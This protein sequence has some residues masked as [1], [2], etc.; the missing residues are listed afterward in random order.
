MSTS[1]SRFSLYQELIDQALLHQPEVRSPISLFEP[2]QYTI[3]L[4]GK[5]IRPMLTMI[6]AGL[7]GGDP[8]QA[9][10]AAVCVEMTHT[11]TLIHDDIMDAADSRRGKPTVFKKW[12]TSKAILAGDSLFVLAMT[13]INKYSN[14]LS[15]YELSD[16]Y[17]VYFNGVQEVCEGQ[18][19]DLE[20][21]EKGVTGSEDYMKMIDGK[22][23]ALLRTALKMGGITAH[24]T[25][26]Q[27]HH[28]SEIGTSLGLAFQIQ[29]DLL[30]VS[31]DFEKLGKTI[32]GDVL[33]GKMTFLMT[34]LL[35]KLSSDKN[36][37]SHY[38]VIQILEKENRNIDDVS[39]ML[40][41]FTTHKILEETQAKIDELYAY[42]ESQLQYFDDTE[43]KEDL[44]DLIR[45]LKHRD[46]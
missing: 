1:P 13:Y 44:A 14:K 16:L 37:E 27:L 33:E 38:E 4:G 24:A 2:Q 15:V 21:A 8:K 46:Y 25:S 45:F 17:Q 28:L 12:G 30:D 18:A 5:R 20:M 26:E 6:A 19:L 39:K 7:C 41:M 29:D 9:L 31:A 40:E 23:S 32:G 36:S 42:S 43:Y 34:S 3:A 35:E 22:T 11:F 10:N